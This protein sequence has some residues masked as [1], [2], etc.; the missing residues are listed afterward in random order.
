MQ[1]KTH[2]PVQSELTDETREAVDAW[3]TQAKLTGDQCVF[4]SRLH[5]SPHLS[6][7]QYAK[8]VDVWVIFDRPRS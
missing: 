3:I 2:S 7:R 6:T 4:L 8:I 1:R 5:A